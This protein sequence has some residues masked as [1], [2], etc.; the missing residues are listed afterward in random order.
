MLAAREVGDEERDGVYQGTKVVVPSSPSKPRQVRGS[1]QQLHHASDS[2]RHSLV[3]QHNS[4][5]S[6]TFGFNICSFGWKCLSVDCRAMPQGY[7]ARLRVPS[8]N[9]SP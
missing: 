9:G 2:R 1:R 3:G 8:L 7:D 6:V 5:P 4:Y